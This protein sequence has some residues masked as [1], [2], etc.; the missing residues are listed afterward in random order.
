MVDE[1]LLQ[2]VADL[3]LTLGAAD[4]HWH[5]GDELLGSGLLDEDVARLRAVAVDDDDLVAGCHE[6]GDAASGVV[7]VD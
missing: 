7:D 1:A 3:A 2:H 5:G 4:V 6:A